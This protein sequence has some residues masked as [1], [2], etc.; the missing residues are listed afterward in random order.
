MDPLGLRGLVT[1]GQESDAI[2]RGV[3]ATG[4][5]GFMLLRGRGGDY[6]G[7]GRSFSC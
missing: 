7:V 1:L 2:R 4:G 3:D 5:T 6:W